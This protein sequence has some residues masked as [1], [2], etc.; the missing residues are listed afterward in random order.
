MNYKSKGL[1][2]RFVINELLSKFS[3][4]S[5]ISPWIIDR[6]LREDFTRKLREDFPGKISYIA[7]LRISIILMIGL[8]PSIKWYFSNLPET[9]KCLS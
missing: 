9:I 8:N 3:I 4:I 7:I 1:L 2:T 5:V 6:N